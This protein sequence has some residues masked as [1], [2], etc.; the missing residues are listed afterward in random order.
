MVTIW[1]MLS[2]DLFPFLYEYMDE[3]SMWGNV[4]QVCVASLSGP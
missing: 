4:S 1:V 2:T 3:I